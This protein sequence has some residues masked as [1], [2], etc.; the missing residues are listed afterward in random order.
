MS[1]AKASGGAP[2]GHDG[3][4]PWVRLRSAGVGPH[5]YARMI[6]EVDPRAKPG[7]LV[8]VY[9]KSGAPYGAALYNP[10]SRIGLRMLSRGLKD[11]NPETALE[12]RV[13][14][15]VE[16]RR[17]ILRLDEVCDAYRVAHDYADGLPGL[18]V[19]RLAD[20]LVLEFYSLGMFR[21]APEIEKCLAPH[22][23]GARMIRRA[24]SHA[25]TMEGFKLGPGP[26]GKTRIREHGVVFE[27]DLGSGAKTGFFCDQRENRRAFAR[28]APGRRVLDVCGYTGGFGLQ[29]LKAG[30]AEATCVE[31]DAQ[32]AAMAERNSSLNRLRL[33][34][35]CVDAFPFL[36]QMA[37]NRERYG[38][39]ALDPHKMISTREGYREGRQKLIDLNRLAISILEPGGILVTCCCAGLVPWDDFHA[40]LRAASGSTGVRLQIFGRTGAGPDHP[41]AADHPEG[42]YLKVLWCRGIS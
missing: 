26:G 33:R 2:A 11:F 7:D 29:A 27:V 13:A 40:L 25:Q 16:F 1:A 8:A 3:A 39:V 5:L 17:N 28:L 42:E 12:E 23:P 18:V 32:A 15:A 41:V 4:L 21:R 9:D 10:G 35:V 6:G 34:V 37:A 14:R 31:L 19:D 38:L 30:A 36:R 24:S 22:F 20:S